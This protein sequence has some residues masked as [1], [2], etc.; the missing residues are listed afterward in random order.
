[1]ADDANAPEKPPA[2]HV[3]VV[4]DDRSSRSALVALLR[5]TG[6]RTLAAGTVAE[7]MRLLSQNPSCLILDLMLPDGNGGS[8]LA[9][10]RQNHLPIHVIVTTGAPDW[11]AMLDDSPAPPDIVFPKPIDFR[12][13]TQWLSDHCRA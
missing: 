5:L 11:R 12:G 8:V 6:F 1:M 2:S 13:L 9:Y 7:A 4:E 3:L 10:I